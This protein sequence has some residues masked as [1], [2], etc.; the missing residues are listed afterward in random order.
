MEVSKLSNLAPYENLTINELFHPEFAFYSRWFMDFVYLLA[1]FMY[2]FAVYVAI[3]KSTQT[4]GFFK[5]TIICQMTANMIVETYMFILN[6]V[7]LFPL[8]IVFMHTHFPIRQSWIYPLTLWSL[9]GIIGC[10]T[11][12]I[13]ALSYRVYM[14]FNIRTHA[15]SIPLKTRYTVL[16][17]FG[18]LTLFVWLTL[19][20]K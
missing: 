13:L 14:V 7:Y 8:P 9:F 1:V 6:P 17:G 20:G 5:H 11:A 3:T 15:F 4:M 12:F 19:S 18:M 2:S 16:T 10:V